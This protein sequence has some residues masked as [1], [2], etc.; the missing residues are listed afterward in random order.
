MKGITSG[1]LDSGVSD[2]TAV[3]DEPPNSLRAEVAVGVVVASRR[4][5]SAAAA[6]D[7]VVVAH[8]TM[9]AIRGR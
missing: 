3:S 6:A 7:V 4:R 8:P 9:P 2:S 5:V 1:V